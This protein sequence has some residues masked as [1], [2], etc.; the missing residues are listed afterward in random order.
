MPIVWV[1]LLVYGVNVVTTVASVLLLNW[2]GRKTLMIVFV[3][4]QALMLI[5]L[6]LFLGWAS[7]SVADT[8]PIICCLA[9]VG[10]F[11]FSSGPITWLYIAEICNDTAQSYATVANQVVCLFMALIPPL[12]AENE[13][14][15]PKLMLTFGV[16]TLFNA[17]VIAFQM[18]ETKNK[19]AD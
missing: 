5:L 19:T 11:E 18:K 6:G 12:V 10:F 16:I 8:W 1:N 15:I 7:D 17:A 3:P 4:A 13:N 9:F 14:G 2:Y